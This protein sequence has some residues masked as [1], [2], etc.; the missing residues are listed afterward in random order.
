MPIDLHLEPVGLLVVDHRE[1]VEIHF[2]KSP[3]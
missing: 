3:R 2:H 1:V